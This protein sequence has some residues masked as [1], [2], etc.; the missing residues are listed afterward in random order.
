MSI[1][2]G[3]YVILSFAIWEG[4]VVKINVWALYMSK[5]CPVLCVCV[6]VVVCADISRRSLPLLR[7]TCSQ[8]CVIIT[9]RTA[10]VE[11]TH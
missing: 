2:S 7:P 1:G 6:Y 9:V 11:N 10:A 3:P 4:F 5:Y 8:Q